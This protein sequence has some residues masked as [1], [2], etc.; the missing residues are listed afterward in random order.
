[1]LSTRL[2]STI[3]INYS[4]IQIYLIVTI[5]MASQAP[6]IEKCLFPPLAF[7]GS[8][9]MTWMVHM[10]GHLTVKDLLHTVSDNFND[11]EN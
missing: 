7:N 10:E 8:N 6:Q 11:V 4:P 3:A 1:M 2:G 5:T 9:Y